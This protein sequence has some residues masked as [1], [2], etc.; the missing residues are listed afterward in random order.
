MIRS[1]KDMSRMD[2]FLKFSVFVIIAPETPKIDSV[3]AVM[4]RV[5]AT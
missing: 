3:G 5:L 2:E 1:K 4:E